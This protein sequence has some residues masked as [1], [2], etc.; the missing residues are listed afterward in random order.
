MKNMNVNI[1]NDDNILGE[2]G[3]DIEDEYSYWII[4]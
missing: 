2:W 1:I 3:I 4:L